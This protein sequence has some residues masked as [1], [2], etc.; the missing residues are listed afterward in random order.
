MISSESRRVGVTGVATPFENVKKKIK[1]RKKKRR[2][3]RRERE[4]E[5]TSAK[6][7]SI[8]ERFGSICTYL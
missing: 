7:N 4:C 2:K 1:Q 8:G 5:L 6:I 3:Q